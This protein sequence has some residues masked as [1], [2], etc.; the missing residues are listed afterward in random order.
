MSYQ[1]TQRVFNRFVL[2]A[3]LISW[4]WSA[5]C[6]SAEAG[7]DVTLNANI[8]ENTCQISIPGEGKVHLSTVGKSWFYNTDGSSRLQPTD[9]ASGTA[10]TVKVESCP[11]DN[12]SISK[13]NFS[14]Q[15]QTKQWPAGSKQIFINETPVTEGGADNTGVVIFSKAFNTNVLN[16]DG[17]S[18]VKLDTGTEWAT[19]YDFYARL[20]NTGPVTSGKVTSRVVVNATYN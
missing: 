8:V 13:M 2:L 5:P 10:F 6:L 4:H 16:S 14:F 1:S 20:Q 9:A 11:G 3:G 19:E 17:T 12:T 7:L 15:P 18:S